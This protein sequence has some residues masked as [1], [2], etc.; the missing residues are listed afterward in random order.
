M[1]QQELND[2]DIPHRTTIR[3][4]VEEVVEEHLAQLKA[5]MQVSVS[6]DWFSSD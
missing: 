5:D 2:S 6:T 3:T 1:L 4:R